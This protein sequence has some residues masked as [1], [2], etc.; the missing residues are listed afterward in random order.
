M[1]LCSNPCQRVAGVEHVGDYRRQSD[2]RDCGIRQDLKAQPRECS[3]KMPALK[4]HRD[5]WITAARGPKVRTRK[6]RPRNRRSS[7]IESLRHA[8]VSGMAA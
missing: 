1:G 6:V 5:V 2:C 3:R 8:M 7:Q 4:P